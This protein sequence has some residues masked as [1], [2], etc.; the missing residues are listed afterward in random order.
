MWE[1]EELPEEWKDLIIVPIYKKI[2]KTDCSNYRNVNYVQNFI[3]HPAVKVNSI[4][5]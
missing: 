3:Q 2:D 5:R 1:K 4:C